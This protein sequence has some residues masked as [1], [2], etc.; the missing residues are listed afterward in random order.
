MYFLCS[1]GDDVSAAQPPPHVNF[2]R[3]F[4]RD[5]FDQELFIPLFRC[6]R[7]DQPQLGDRNFDDYSYERWTWQ[8]LGMLS[9]AVSLASSL[10]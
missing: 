2:P 5:F 10:M 8:E 4:P 1:N 3:I 7:Y 6:E 9:T